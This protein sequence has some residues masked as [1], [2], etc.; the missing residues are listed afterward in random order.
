MTQRGQTHFYHTFNTLR[1]VRLIILTEQCTTAKKCVCFI[2]KT[3]ATESTR[4][5]LHNRLS[6]VDR[7][8]D[9]SCGT[10][11]RCVLAGECYYSII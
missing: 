8:D 3:E 7:I 6:A 5:I 4:R 10:R 11:S 2:F 1:C 9:H